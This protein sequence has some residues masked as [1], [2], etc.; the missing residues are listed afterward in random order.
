MTKIALDTNI[1]IYLTKETFYELWLKLKEGKENND[2]EII[3]NDII[4]KEWAR[5]KFKT[6][7][8]LTDNIKNEYKT[9]LNLSQY[10]SGEEKDTFVQTLSFY[11]DEKNRIKK[12]EE[13]VEEIESFMNS[14]III[15]TTQEQKLFISE[16]AI[17]KLPPFQNNKNSF[18]DSLIVRNIAEYVKDEFPFQYDLIYVSNNPDDFIDKQTKEIYPHLLQGLEHVRIKNVT[19]LGEALKLAP[20]VVEDFDAWLEQKLDDQAMYE[21]DIRRGK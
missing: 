8:N 16:L 15:N 17:D 18:N 2:F 9:A 19:E 1:W 12:A 3:V 5:N 7:K 11:K 4:L 10:L 6:I 21:F 20:E 14:C 13:R